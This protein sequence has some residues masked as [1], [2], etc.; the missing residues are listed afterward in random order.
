MVLSYIIPPLVGS[1]IG[2][3]TND[4]A[5]KM[6][7]RPHH[8]KYIFG[9]KVPFTPGI[10]PKEKG[11]LAASIGMTISENLMNREV[12]GKTL[13][14]EEI[15]N[16]MRLSIDKFFASQRHNDET[17]RSFL[18]RFLSEEEIRALSEKGSE[19]LTQLVYKKLAD[20][21]VGDRIAHASVV[22]V[23]EKMQHFGSVGGSQ[24]DERANNGI[25][26]IIGRGIKRIFGPKGTEA[27]SQF[28]NALAAPLER[29][30]SSHINEMLRTNSKEIVGDLILKESGDL[31]SRKMSSLLEGKEE[32]TGR[33]RETLVSLYVTTI[34][35]RLPRILAAVDLSKVIE[36][37]INEMDMNEA[38]KIIL[39]VLSKELR[40]I[41]WLGAGLGFIMGFVNLLTKYL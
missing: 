25:G 29:S 16:K 12:L 24:S 26:D 17:L 39:D 11:R 35:V 10:I 7:F 37:R 33:I 40:A 3:I 41:V 28:V 23:M 14:S 18:S 8:A 20:S 27:T 19:D 1:V 31:L 6:L 30:L 36:D 22:H 9:H 13:L 34:E 4:I 5:I 15:L 38:E 2:Y 32:E 21:D